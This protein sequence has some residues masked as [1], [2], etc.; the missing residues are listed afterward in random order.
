M[1]AEILAEPK[2]R[3]FHQWQLTSCQGQKRVGQLHASGDLDRHV[4]GVMTGITQH[5]PQVT[6]TTTIFYKRRATQVN[7]GNSNSNNNNSNSNS[8]S[9]NSN[10]NGDS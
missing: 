7:I 9:N 5:Q 4:T 3:Q 2:I 10:S 8:N 1:H 6:A